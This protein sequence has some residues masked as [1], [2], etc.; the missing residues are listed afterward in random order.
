MKR[1]LYIVLGVLVLLVAG[2]AFAISRIDTASFTQKIADVTRDATGK[3]LVLSQAPNISVMPLGVSFG[4]AS[5]GMQDGK[6][7]AQGISASIQGGT[8]TMQL[9]P[10]FSGK[11]VVDEV[12]LNSPSISIRPEAKPT[13]RPTPEAKAEALTIPP[14]EL[15]QL[16]I[17]NGTVDMDMGQGQNLRLTKLD[18]TMRD[19]M[20]NKEATLQ[21]S[22]HVDITQA[23]QNAAPTTVIAGTL[24]QKIQVRLAPTQVDFQ[25]LDINF[26][27]E[28][29]LIPASLGPIH[30]AGSGSCQLDKQALQLKNFTISVA[31]ANM[32]LSGE[33]QMD[34]LSFKGIHSLSLAPDKLLKSLGMAAPLPQMPQSFTQKSSVNFANNTL[35]TS[36]YVATL[37]KSNITA[38]ASMTLPQ[39]GKSP[40]IVKKNVRIDHLNLDQ[41]LGAG[42]ATSE[43]IG[44]QSPKQGPAALPFKA[45]DLPTIDVD[46]TITSLTVRKIPLE[47]MHVAIKGSAG[48]YIINPAAFALGTG[49]TVTTNSTMSLSDMRYSSQGKAT[50]I[51]VGSLLQALQGKSPISG[52]AQLDYDLACSGASAAAIKSSLSGKGLLL[53]QNIVLKDVTLLPKDAPQKGGVPSNFERLQVPFTAKNG[54]V[55]INPLTLTSPTLNAKGQGTVNLPQ[56]N[57]N[58]SADIAMLGLTLPV[59]ASGPFS[60]LSYGLDPKKMLQNVLSTPG[61]AA[62][63][64]GNLLQQGGKGAKDVGGGLRNLFKK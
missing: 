44:K 35:S 30:L 34:P 22:V 12:L 1:I 31:H 48:R 51:N 41:Y 18:V 63:G 56:E 20:P 29:G 37:D 8:I 33:L 23:A 24:N 16:R 21:T 7:A 64:A 32:S 38:S 9:M 39:T 58:M 3:P 42:T 17:S 62:K 10:L 54:I 11:V 13:T 6:A 27:P 26:T 57:L 61:A 43:T 60:N 19:L 52:T 45:A 46:I 4:P 40:L 28:K 15:T 36:D 2:G 59:V 49:G 5:W 25:G 47:N 50:N 14:V 55:S 53:V